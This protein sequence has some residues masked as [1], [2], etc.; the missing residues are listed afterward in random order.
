MNDPDN[1][2]NGE[3]QLSMALMVFAGV[4]FAGAFALTPSAVSGLSGPPL[5]I[6]GALVLVAILALV[7]SVYIGGRGIAYGPGGPGFF[8]DRF[9]MQAFWGGIAFLCLGISLGIYF[10]YS[11]PTKLSSEVEARIRGIEEQLREVEARQTE[12][13]E[14]LSAVRE[15]CSLRSNPSFSDGDQAENDSR[16]EVRDV[17]SPC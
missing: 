12:F 11:E 14:G 5:F 6:T 3:S 4:V 17:A 9:N 2:T 8:E 13:E 16:E 15:T 10:L 7:L 1:P